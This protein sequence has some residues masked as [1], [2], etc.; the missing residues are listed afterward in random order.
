MS[1]FLLKRCTVETFESLQPMVKQY[2][3]DE[4]LLMY[5]QVV[6]E[7]NEE[8]SYKEKLE[9]RLEQSDKRIQELMDQLMLL[10]R[11]KYVGKSER[12]LGSV[13]DLQGTL[14]ELEA[15]PEEEVVEKEQITY[16]RRKPSEKSDHAGRNPLPENLLV[17]DITM[18]HSKADP[19]TMIHIGTD[20]S[21]R[22]SIKPAQLFVKRYL[23]PKYKDPATGIIY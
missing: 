20:I 23:Y 19:D 8:I 11:Q 3:Y 16:E 21:K 6:A 22:L 2:T 12:Q 17:E 1:Y 4:L 18:L 13:N 5:D 7:R 14:F 9:K 10:L 15:L